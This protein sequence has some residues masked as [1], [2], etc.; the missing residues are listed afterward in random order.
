MSPAEL[1]TRQELAL[2]YRLFDVF[3]WHEL[4]YNHITVRVPGEPNCFLINQ[5]GLLYGEITASNLVK[6]DLDGRVLGGTGERINPAG[7]VVHSAVHASRE[8][9]HAVIHT[10]TTAGQVVAC[11]REGLLPL[12]FTSAFFQDRIAYHDFEGITLDTD[13]S[14]RLARDLGNRNIMILRNHGLLTCGKTLAEA[15][16]LHYHL[17][18]ACEV[19]MGTP[20]SSRLLIEEGVAAR[21]TRQ[22]AN[23]IEQGDEAALLLTAMRRWMERRDPSFLA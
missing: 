22:F 3:G 19:Q 2:V 10:H 11:S 14:K 6:V 7:F 23:A 20:Q 17:Q 15:F 12:S 1:Q 5:F 8:D 9:A 21:A 4:I 18:R 13:E 16:A